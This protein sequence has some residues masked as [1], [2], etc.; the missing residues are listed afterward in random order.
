VARAGELS[1]DLLTGSVLHGHDLGQPGTGQ[2]QSVHGQVL[3]LVE[4]VL[5]GGV[6]LAL[7]GGHRQSEVEFV[8]HLG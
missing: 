5:Q 6:R 3:G 4:G 2:E 8:G 1:D 7:F